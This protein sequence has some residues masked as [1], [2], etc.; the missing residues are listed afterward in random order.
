MDRKITALKAQKRNPQRVNVFLDGEFAFGLSRIEAAW[1]QIG[2]ELSA[3]KIREL[4]AADHKETAYQKALNFLSYRPRSENEVR[5]NLRKHNISDEA[6]PDVLD[7]LRRN[8]LVDDT[9]FAQTWVENR[10]EFRPRG[11]RALRMELRQKGIGD[12]II[13]DVFQDLDEDALAY[14]AALK[15]FRKYRGLEQPDYRRKMSDFLARR[16]F[17]YGVAA[18]VVERVWA[19]E[20]YNL[21]TEDNP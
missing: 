14:R 21:S 7:R 10:S 8:G 12:D 18:P 3:E 19:E 9:Q 2:Q 17:G 13:E 11:R 20:Q 16:G 6:I 5:Q 4:Q 15:Q 1:L